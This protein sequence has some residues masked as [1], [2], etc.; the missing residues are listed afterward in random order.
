[1]NDKIIVLFTGFVIGV[2]PWNVFANACTNGV[3]IK[4]HVEAIHSVFIVPQ[5]DGYVSRVCFREGGAVKK[6]DL[7]YQLD[8]RRFRYQVD[9][10]KAE[11]DA[12]GVAVEHAQREFNR[13]TAVDSRGVTQVEIDAASLQCVIAKSSE[14]QAKASYDI[15]AFDLEKTQIKAPMDGRIGASAV[16]PGS[17]V[18]P[19]HEPLA[20]IVQVDPIRVVFPVPYV[21][22]V[23]Y[24]KSG[25]P[26]S[27]VLRPI[28]II[29]PN[30]VAYDHAGRVDFE[31]NIVNE[32]DG[33]IYLGAQFPNPDQLLL[34]NAIVDVVVT[35][36]V[37][38]GT[39]NDA[40]PRRSTPCCQLPTR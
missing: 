20:R 39:L 37:T 2:L 35:A 23:K 8:E 21:E 16:G 9:S 4:G 7:L 29:L 24:K 27:D 40:N 26:I 14:Q 34:P 25:K 12:S 6:G 18:S 31:N 38:P 5:I 19:I 17:Y 3:P 33:S 30:G 28:K 32:G 10:C 13:M 22:Y 1:M 11:L 15:A 36:D